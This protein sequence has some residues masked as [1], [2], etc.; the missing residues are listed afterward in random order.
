MVSCVDVHVCTCRSVETL[1]AFVGCHELSPLRHLGVTGV[2]GCGCGWCVWCVCLWSVHVHTHTQRTRARTHTHTHTHTNTYTCMHAPSTHSHTHTHIHTYTHVCM[3]AYTHTRIQTYAHTRVR[4]H[5]H[6][7]TVM[8]V[9]LH[10]CGDLASTLLRIFVNRHAL[11][12]VSRVPFYLLY[13]GAIEFVFVIHG[14]YR[15]CFSEAM[16][17]A[18]RN[19]RIR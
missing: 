3:H 1:T 10:T 14:R 12:R 8:L 6:T 15:E 16:E 9:G 11:S 7:G 13:T 17:S 2:C 18:F 19:A 4:T 5:T